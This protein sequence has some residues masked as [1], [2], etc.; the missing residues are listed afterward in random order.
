MTIWADMLAGTLS[1]PVGTTKLVSIVV[2][3][4]LTFPPEETAFVATDV[5]FITPES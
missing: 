2:A 1:D 3:S 5:V 4:W